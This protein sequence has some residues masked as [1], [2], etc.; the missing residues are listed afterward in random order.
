MKQ[1]F[2]VRLFSIA[3]LFLTVEAFGQLPQSKM[4]SSL[5]SSSQIEGIKPLEPKKEPTTPK[6]ESLPAPVKPPPMIPQRADYLHPG[7]LVFLN[8]R[9]E[10]SDHLFNI[11]SHIGVYVSI[12]KPQNE[13]LDI[14]EHQIQQEIEK[15]FSQVHIQPQ[16]LTLM[17]RPPL[18]AF[19]VEIFVYPIE[20][21]YTAFCQGRLFE[22]VILERF[23]MDPNMAFQ[24]ITWEKQQLIISP[25]FQFAE[26]LLNTV[27]EITTTFT[28]RYQ[29][30]ERMKK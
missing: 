1:F 16:T 21:G 28:E 9:W 30:Y 14:T 17:G 25:K 2:L 15:L 6:R 18:P 13:D 7:I 4:G 8:G 22:S 5:K 11:S 26:Q 19:E 3:S 27:R 23:K 12:I 29:V 24:A 20:K 10:G